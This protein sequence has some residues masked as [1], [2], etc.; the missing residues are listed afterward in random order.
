MTDHRQT[1]TPIE[2]GRTPN[3]AAD[4]VREL[5]KAMPHLLEVATLQ[6]KLRKANFDALKAAGF[7]EAQALELCKNI[8]S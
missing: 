5:R 2:G 7:N 1:I 8:L 4:A 3:L 6:A